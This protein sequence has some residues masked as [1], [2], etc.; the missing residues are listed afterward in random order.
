ME[1]G[2]SAAL[3]M[4]HYLRSSGQPSIFT[5]GKSRANLMGT[6]LVFTEANRT[7]SYQ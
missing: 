1:A 3:I 2:Q 4:N 6:E 7:Q 5:P